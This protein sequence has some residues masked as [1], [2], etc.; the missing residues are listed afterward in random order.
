MEIAEK[1]WQAILAAP[2]AKEYYS[3]TTTL[4]DVA[5]T[6]V[7]FRTRGNSSLRLWTQ[8]GSERYPFRLKFDKYVDNQRFLGLDELVLTNSVDDASFLRDYLGYEA[9]RQLGMTVPYVTFFDL[10]IN[11]ELRGLYVGIEAVDNRFLNRAFGGHKGNL[12]EAGIFATLTVNMD[13]DSMEQKKGKDES[14]TDISELI[15]I[16]RTMPTGQKGEIESIL[17]VDSVLRYMAANAV[18]HNWDDYAGIFA[19]NYYFYVE[20]G[21]F[22]IIPWDMNEA[23]LQTG[24][25]YRP[26]DGSRQDIATPIT[27]DLDPVDRPLASKLL[28][29]PEYYT[30]YLDYCETLR[31]WLESLPDTLTALF[32]Q[33]DASVEQDP[34]KFYTYEEFVRQFDSGYRDGLAGFIADR[35]EYL[36]ER[37]PE[38]M[39]NK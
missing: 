1:D 16:L 10:Y 39:G 24:P 15:R 8:R 6:D 28:A 35:A 21:I 37:L 17:D 14:K 3:V 22:H 19:H 33:L 26:S 12:Y 2:R 25:M 36:A 32:E 29:V 13:L 31:K 34:T 23:F 27:G 18:V 11:G 5:I 9:F 4:D 20:D 30:R 7:G 38:L